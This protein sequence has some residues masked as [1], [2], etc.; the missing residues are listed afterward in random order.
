MKSD[1]I[2]LHDD[3]VFDVV[4]ESIP[5]EMVDLEHTKFGTIRLHRRGIF[6]MCSRGASVRD[7]ANI[8]GVSEP[9]LYAHVGY[10]MK[11]GKSFIGPRLKYNLLKQ[12]YRED[13]TNAA[14]LIFALKNWTELTEDGHN[15]VE[16]FDGKPEW[17]VNPPKFDHKQTLTDSER[18]EIEGDDE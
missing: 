7:L 13:K 18:E 16:E 17:K 12:A 14:L 11:A 9:T 4:L 2:D 6:K 1:D 5:D 15:D 10:E 3:T 8:F